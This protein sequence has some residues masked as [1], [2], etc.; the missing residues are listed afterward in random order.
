MV[1]F[2]PKVIAN[3]AIIF[4]LISL[5]LVSVVFVGYMMR[6]GYILLGLLWVSGFFV[7]TNRWTETWRVLPEKEFVRRIFWI[8]VA[9]RLI[10]VVFSYYFYMGQTGRPFEFGAA[11]SIG[12][13]DEAAWMAESDWPFIWDTCTDTAME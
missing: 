13:H 12:Y 2:F 3:R 1:P 7:L 4:Y 9:I 5:S 11:D 10:W 8:A 6:W